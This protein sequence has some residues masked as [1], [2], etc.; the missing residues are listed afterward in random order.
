MRPSHSLVAKT[1]ISHMAMT[2]SCKGVVTPSTAPKEM[3]TVADAKS[4]FN[5]L[6]ITELTWYKF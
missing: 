4:A 5:R 3:S 1:A 2:I 6:Q